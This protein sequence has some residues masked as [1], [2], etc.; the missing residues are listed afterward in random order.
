MK[1]R[2]T[3]YMA[4]AV[5]IGA[6]LGA[7]GMHMLSSTVYGYGYTARFIADASTDLA[8]LEK[9]ASNQPDE[10]EAILKMRLHGSMIALDADKTNLTASQLDTVQNLEDRARVFLGAK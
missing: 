8:A 3:I 6:A 7:F 10:V 1:S 9:L 2:I 4:V 5:L